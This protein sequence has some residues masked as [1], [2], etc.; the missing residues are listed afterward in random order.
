MAISQRIV[1]KRFGL[2]LT[3]LYDMN[4]LFGQVVLIFIDVLV[5]HECCTSMLFLHNYIICIGYDMDFVYN[6]NLFLDVYYS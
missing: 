6:G 4:I 3:E 2:A 5:L 1:V